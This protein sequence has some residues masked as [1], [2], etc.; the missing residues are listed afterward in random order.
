MK[1]TTF[2][3]KNRSRFCAFGLSGPHR[4]PPRRV[5]AR[6]A[7]PTASG[8]GGGRP[9]W[10]SVENMPAASAAGRD[11][12]VP[13]GGSHSVRGRRGATLAVVRGE[14]AGGHLAAGR[15]KPVPYGGF[16]QR[17]GRRGGDPCGRPRR[18]CRGPWWRDGTSP[19]P[20]AGSHSDRGGVGATLAV[21][22]GEHAGGLGGGTGQARPLRRVP[23]ASGTAWGRPLRSSA[24]NMPA[25]SAAGRDK[26]V[27]YD[28]S[29]SVRGRRGGDPCG[30]PRRTCRRTPGSGTGQARPLRRV[31][32]ASGTAWGRPLWSSAENMPGALVAGRD[33]PVPYGGFPQRPGRRRGDPC[34][35]PRRT[36]RRPWWRD[37]TSPSPASQYLYVSGLNGPSAATLM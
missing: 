8:D 1:P 20:A 27:P 26:P 36:C 3:T 12:P 10:S 4:A 15:D 9:S 16:P 21:V 29:H 25:A 37:G 30:R 14:H 22:R 24:E 28:G 6:G 5:V 18:T 31:P 34:G 7:F 23:T 33:K 2:A 19:S 17:P 13:Y 11:K 35:R 32:T